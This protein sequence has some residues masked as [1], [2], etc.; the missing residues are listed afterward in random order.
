MNMKRTSRHS[1]IMAVNILHKKRSRNCFCTEKHK[2]M[3]TFDEP[4]HREL[5]RQQL[6]YCPYTALCGFSFNLYLRTSWPREA[7]PACRDCSCAQN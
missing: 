4:G 2:H 1:G 3:E 7:I 6:L 5:I